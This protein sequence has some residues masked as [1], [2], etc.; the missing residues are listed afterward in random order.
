MKGGKN[1]DKFAKDYNVNNL[2]VN[3]SSNLKIKLAAGGAFVAILK[4]TNKF[5][6]F[7]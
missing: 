1:T 4:K 2:V 7:G 5:S 3:N 6:I